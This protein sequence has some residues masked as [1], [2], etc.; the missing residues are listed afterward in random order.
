M[1]T[2]TDTMIIFILIGII[3]ILVILIAI[4]DIANK[5]RQRL[6]QEV[7]DVLKELDEEEDVEEINDNLVEPVK[8]VPANV[9]TNANNN[10]IEEIKYVEEDEELEK[11]KAKIELAK[12]KE[13]LIRQEEEK[14]QKALE[15]KEEVEQIEKK[16]EIVEKKVE[17]PNPTPKVEVVE[18]KA[19]PPTTEVS[20]IATAINEEIEK[21]E[22]E[23]ANLSKANAVQEDLNEILSM[24]ID[25]QIN[26]HEDEQEAKAI[27][28][29]DE[30]NKIS[31][32]LYDSNEVVQS[33][34]QDEGNEPISLKELEDLYNTR[35]ME[36][37]KLDDFNTI[38]KKDKKSEKKVILE[39]A[40]IKKMEDLPPITSE[41]KFK[42]SPFIS[43]IFG[44]SEKED[45]IELEQ[46]ADLDKLNDEVKK[47]NEFLKTLKELQKNL[48]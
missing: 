24:S 46:T 8:P 18:A 14:K 25:D 47:T 17:T 41:K 31:D 34:Y 37:I 30:F 29:V 32:D 7:D 45:N 22:L 23:E 44:L 10:R 36:V 15:P 33:A 12:L 3:F 43:P 1:T 38:D 35:E 2:S 4:I 27:I 13:E 6:D 19:T 11:T 28:S 9:T 48:D 26:Y 40:D 21:E 16:E 20:D 5:K 39:Q 42:S